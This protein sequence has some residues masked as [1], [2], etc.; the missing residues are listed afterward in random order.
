MSPTSNG[1]VLGKMSFSSRRRCSCARTEITSYAASS[2]A[3]NSYIYL[4]YASKEQNPL[5]GYG[6]DSLAKIRAVAEK[7]DPNRVFQY[8]MLGGFKVS[9]VGLPLTITSQT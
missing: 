9:R 2:G 1:K 4:N 6:S 8:M 5:E 3:D 7:Y